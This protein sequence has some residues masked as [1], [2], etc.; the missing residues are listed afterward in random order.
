MFLRSSTVCSF[1]LFFPFVFFFG[2]AAYIRQQ[3]YQ[4]V[5]KTENKCL[6]LRPDKGQDIVLINRDDCNN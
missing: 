3:K 1:V 2:F 4:N 5:A 6:I